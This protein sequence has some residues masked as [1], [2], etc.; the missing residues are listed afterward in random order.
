[1]KWIYGVA[2][3]NQSFVTIFELDIYFNISMS[4]ECYMNTI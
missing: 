3:L 4:E 1:M 2:K